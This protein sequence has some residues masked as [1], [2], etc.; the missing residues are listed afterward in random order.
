MSLI[1]PANESHWPSWKKIL[2]RFFFIYFPLQG[3]PWLLSVFPIIRASVKYY[4]ILMDRVVRIAN[5]RLFH[6]KTVLI[7]RQSFRDTSWAWAQQWLFLC[8]ALAGCIVWSFFDRK[9]KKYTE[10]NHWL[11]VF[12]RYCIAIVS[13]NYGIGKIFALQI[14]FPNQS[15]L[16]TPL[17][18]LLPMRL[19]WASIGY[20]KTYEVFAGVMEIF[21]GVFLLYRKTITLGALLGVAVYS[22]LMLLNISYDIPVKLLTINLVAFCLFLIANEYKRILYFFVLNI[23]AP[24]SH[25]HN[26]SYS[27]KWMRTARIILKAGFILIY[28]RNLYGEWHRSK[29]MTVIRTVNPIKP[30]IY[31][32]ITYAV[33]NDTMPALINDSMRWHDV[34]FENQGK[35]SVGTADTSFRQL[36]KRGYFTFKTDTVTHMINFKKGRKDSSMYNG[37]ILSLHYSIPDSNTI[38]LWGKRKNDSMYIFLKRSN[39]HFQLTEKQFHWLTEYSR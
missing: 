25:V 33:N 4:N 1:T 6:I 13:L 16:A 35:G 22:N 34:I 2:F 10:L 8:I 39:R 32:V 5:A 36:Y 19:Y 30:G 15:L 3:L 18:D 38:Q 37:V 28:V 29:V 14:P 9:R 27:R 12:A 20:S 26:L 24:V 17:G 7:P 21:T 31:D 11:C 23:A